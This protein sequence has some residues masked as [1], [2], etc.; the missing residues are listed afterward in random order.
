[1]VPCARSGGQPDAGAGGPGRSFKRKLGGDTSD[2]E[3]SGT[4][5]VIPSS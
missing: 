3:N 2:A 5:V 4:A 1:M